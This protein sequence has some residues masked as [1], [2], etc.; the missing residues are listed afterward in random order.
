MTFCILDTEH[1]NERNIYICTRDA[2]AFHYMFCSFVT[3]T[4]LRV[5]S[6]SILLLYNGF[7]HRID[8]CILMVTMNDEH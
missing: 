7:Y 6:F 1:K 5:R 3:M 8:T 2:F 4:C